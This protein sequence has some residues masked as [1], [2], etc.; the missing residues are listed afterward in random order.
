M[1][2]AP[3]LKVLTPQPGMAVVEVLG[4]HDL[5]TQD[6]AT[7]LFARLVAEHDVVVVDLSETLFIDSSFL[8]NL[9]TAQRAA[10]QR[11][12]TVLLQVGTEPIVKRM[13][14]IS[15]FLTH[16][17]HVSSREEALAWAPQGVADVA[18]G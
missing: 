12:R 6:E 9:R 11:G 16:F 7:A 1:D 14:E 8:K 4:E 3:E 2:I 15:N 18:F 13:L 17:D 10:E 5:S